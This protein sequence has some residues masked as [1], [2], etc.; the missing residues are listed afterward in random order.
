MAKNKVS[1]SNS[2]KISLIHTKKT[3]NGSIYSHLFN[4]YVYL[5]KISKI[6]HY[7]QQKYYHTNQKSS[8]PKKPNAGCSN[9]DANKVFA[10]GLAIISLFGDTF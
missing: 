5:Q 2:K 9:E 7:Q 4:I 1:I 6:K 8:W 3:L 10:K